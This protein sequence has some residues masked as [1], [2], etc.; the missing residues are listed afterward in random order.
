MNLQRFTST[1]T[2]IWMDFAII[3]CTLSSTKL[4]GIL[5]VPRHDQLPKKRTPDRTSLIHFAWCERYWYELS[6]GWYSR[7]CVI[8]ENIYDKGCSTL[9]QYTHFDWVIGSVKIIR[10]RGGK[11]QNQGGLGVR[12][13]GTGHRG[14]P[15]LPG[16]NT[17]Q[18]I[19]EEGP[20]QVYS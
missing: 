16:E 11:Q 1:P 8:S 17:Q 14:R 13:Y 4:E 5:P 18:R 3:L 10:R 19:M 6:R 9:Q 15:C 20:A 12:V 7:I 2:R